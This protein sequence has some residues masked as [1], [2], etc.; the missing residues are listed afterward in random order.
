[1]GCRK[2]EG[3]AN[4]PKH[5]TLAAPSA[6]G[7][8]TVYSTSKGSNKRCAIH[9]EI[10]NCYNQHEDYM[11]LCERTLEQQNDFEELARRQLVSKR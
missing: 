4:T 2:L 11:L 3:I 8:V 7:E 1:M 5:Y 6:E 10:L 9:M